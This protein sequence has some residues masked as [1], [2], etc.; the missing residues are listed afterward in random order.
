MMK[1]LEDLA[2]YRR[3]NVEL[4]GQNKKYKVD[5]KVLMNHIDRLTK[6]TQSA[7][8][9]KRLVEERQM[10]VM[11]SLY[12]DTLPNIEQRENEKDTIS[13]LTNKIALDDA[14][15]RNG[16]LKSLIRRLN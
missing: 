4:K 7:E 13:N 2:H 12:Q 16:Q 11:K 5:N 9:K 1:Q 3:E 6:V 10:R 8:E 15:D 14:T